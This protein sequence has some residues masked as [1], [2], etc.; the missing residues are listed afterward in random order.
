MTVL[1]LKLLIEDL[2]QRV[3]EDGALVVAAISNLCDRFADR[4]AQELAKALDDLKPKKKAAPKRA[5]KTAL[6]P[7]EIVETYIGQLRSALGDLGATAEV[8]K[9]LKADKA[10]KKGDAI[11]IAAGLGIRTTSKT[12]KAQAFT[13]IEGFSHQLERDRVTAERIRRGA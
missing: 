6:P 7:T 12:P 2:K 4:S 1:D 8:M 13:Q 3:D 5:P 10:V 9:R 11:A